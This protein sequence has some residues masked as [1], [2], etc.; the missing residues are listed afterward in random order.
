MSSSS[1]PPDLK[2]DDIINGILVFFN[3]LMGGMLWFLM[4]IL[5]MGH[6]DQQISIRGRIEYDLVKGF[7]FLGIPLILYHLAMQ[8]FMESESERHLPWGSILILGIGSVQVLQGIEHAATAW[9]EHQSFDALQ[10]QLHQALLNGI[11]LDGVAPSRVIGS[12]WI[13]I[14]RIFRWLFAMVG[15]TFMAGFQG[16]VP[17]RSVTWVMT[18]CVTSLAVWTAE[19]TWLFWPSLPPEWAVILRPWVQTTL[20]W[21][22]YSLVLYLQYMLAGLLWG[23]FVFWGKK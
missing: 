5:W 2:F 19:A 4:A 10:K 21:D 8:R 17:L 23:W 13:L 9:L 18:A 1:M 11:S 20:L 16:R 15:I 12:G 14:W 3:S 22:G 6:V 7:T